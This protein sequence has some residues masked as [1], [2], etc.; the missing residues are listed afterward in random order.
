MLQNFRPDKIA[1]NNFDCFRP[2][3]EFVTHQKWMH[4]DIAGVMMNKSDVCYIGKGMS[5]MYR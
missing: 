4:L 2:V 5:G 1:Q 3:Q